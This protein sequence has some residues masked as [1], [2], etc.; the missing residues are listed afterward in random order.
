MS[1]PPARGTGRPRPSGPRPGRP[2]RASRR[3]AA[4]TAAGAAGLLVIGGVAGTASGAFGGGADGSPTASGS[5][6]PPSAAP[7]RAA[8]DAPRPTPTRKAQPKRHKKAKPSHKPTPR[9]THHRPAKTAPAKPKAPAAPVGGTAGRYAS[10]V[11]ALVNAERA[12]HG[13]RALT[14]NSR[15]ARAAQA[16][17]SD[18]R[19]RN[20]FDHTDP[21]GKDPGDRITAA[22]YRWSSYGENIA[23]GQ[24]TP[25]SV[26]DAWM[27]SS[28][29][30]ANI[31][32][33]GFKEIGVGVVL[34]GG[35]YWTQD[36]GTSR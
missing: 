10:Q 23:K 28:G 2:R 21:D 29:H 20:F 4:W 15:L 35:P 9:T 32:N 18:M 33:C 16:F 6:L 14:V 7:S 12:K 36:F 19:A 27:H 11:V 22:G 31:L 30:R 8:A 24:A 3:V 5:S 17:S 26:M 1:Y 34:S 13:C 25:A